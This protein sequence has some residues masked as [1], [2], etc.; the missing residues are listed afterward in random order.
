MTRRAWHG[1]RSRPGGIAGPGTVALAGGEAMSRLDGRAL[2][3]G[4]TS[5][6]GR[7]MAEALLEA[8]MEVVLAARDQK[9]LD[10]VAGASRARGLRAQSAQVDVRDPASV[11][12]LADWVGGHPGGLDLL[13]NNAGIGMRTVNPRFMTDPQP[14]FEVPIAGFEDVVRT[15]LTGY[16]LVARA[17]APL[18]LRQGHGR[19]VNITMNIETMQR[20]GF[21]P[22]GP[23]RAGAE[24]LSRIMA[25]DLRPYGI[26]VNQLL[27]GGAT[28]TGMIPDGL[29]PAGLLQPEIM[30]PPI[31]FLASAAAAGLTGE[32]IVA[33]DFD[34]WLRDHGFGS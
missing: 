15:N 6:I 23:A 16:F 18:F 8:G 20:R 34:L 1:I 11:A 25:E 21:V 29:G 2:V 19:I 33:K 30:G 22:Y 17:F 5:G 28:A 26:A 32:R 9:R 24:A 31:V 13:V 10:D 12:Q 27:P 4:G 14:F 7:A 3:T